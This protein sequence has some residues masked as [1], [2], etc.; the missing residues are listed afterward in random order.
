MQK[1]TILVYTLYSQQMHQKQLEVFQNSPPGTRKVVLCTNIAETSLTIKG[2][3][4]VIDSGVVKRM[5]YSA[6]TGMDTLKVVKTAQDQSW[7]RTGRAGRDSPGECYRT[8]TMA[9]YE[10]MLPNTVPEILRSNIVATV[11]QLSA[12]G[13]DCKSFDFLDK[14]ADSAIEDAM[15]Q[16]HALDAIKSA[17]D[18]TLTELGRKMSRFPLNPRFSK[19]LL[20]APEY[21]CLAD[22]LTIVAILSGE[23]IFYESHDPDVKQ[24][25]LLAHAKFA[26]EHGDHLTLLNVYRAF[27]SSVREKSWCHENCLNYRNLNYARDVRGQLSDICEQLGLAMGSCGDDVD[28]VSA[29]RHFSCILVRNNIKVL[30][31]F[32][33]QVRQCL[34]TGLFNNVAH[35]S[36][37]NH[38][39][40]TTAGRLK[41]KVHPSSKLQTKPPAVMFTELLTTGQCYMRYVTA[42]EADWIDQSKTLKRYRQ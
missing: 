42:I 31:F 40:K 34:L 35:L 14:P 38:T 30:S 1:P 7:Q 17:T 8:Y 24:R 16:L 22:C 4:F 39:Y 32:A 33:L 23:N 18:S 41:V 9:E 13:I 6:L 26:S 20:A 28:K 10:A 3:K 36:T 11:L 25:A 29:C 5:H 37:D 27:A 19:I 12:I 2:I 21:E 15:A